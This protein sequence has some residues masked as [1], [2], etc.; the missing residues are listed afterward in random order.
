[1]SDDNLAN[2]TISSND[3]EKIYR[4]LGE[5]RGI[6]NLFEDRFVEQQEVES[7]QICCALIDLAGDIEL[8]LPE[9]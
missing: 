7:Y 1:M 2:L 5:I 3:L 6:L 9:M 8:L 4:K